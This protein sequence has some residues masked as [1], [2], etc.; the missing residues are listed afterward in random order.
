MADAVLNEPYERAAKMSC[1]SIV[2]Y[3][4][5]AWETRRATTLV[6]R[7]WDYRCNPASRWNGVNLHRAAD[8]KRERIL[9]NSPMVVI[10]YNTIEFEVWKGFERVKEVIRSLVG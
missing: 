4:G 10:V 5:L 8:A 7:G 1:Q 9:T 6:A 2:L 3:W